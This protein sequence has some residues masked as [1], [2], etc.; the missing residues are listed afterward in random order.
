MSL[1]KV[2]LLGNVGR[3]PEVRHLDSGASV[4]SF[5]LAT[6]ERFRDKSGAVQEKTE[7][8]NIVCWRGLADICEKYVKKGTQLLIE[9]KIR[10]RD[11]MDKS[12]QKRY[13]TEIVADTMQLV[14]R[15]SD[16]PAAQSG[17]YSAQQPA[18]QPVQHP[19]YHSGSVPQPQNP[20]P[21]T[22][23]PQDFPGEDDPTDDLPF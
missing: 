18:S 19:S 14:G 3:D 10:T 11:Y 4:A 8:H 5:T 15:K 2:I 6:S 16:N 13:V 7:W 17:G 22:Q 9:G 21:Q 23:G 12:N 20:Q 1:N